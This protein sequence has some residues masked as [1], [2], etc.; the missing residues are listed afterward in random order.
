MTAVP[1]ETE[2]KEAAVINEGT[3]DAAGGTAAVTAA[4]AEGAGAG[5]ATGAGPLLAAAGGEPGGVKTI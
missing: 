5:A 1:P 4:A 3:A 2:A